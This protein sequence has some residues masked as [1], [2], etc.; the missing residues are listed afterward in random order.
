MQFII[1]DPEYEVMEKAYYTF[2]KLDQNK[3]NRISST[4][5]ENHFGAYSTASAKVM[6]RQIDLDNDGVITKNDWIGYWE[7]VRRAGYKN[8]EI[9]QAVPFL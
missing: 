4:E 7:L 8:A 1:Q 9:M 3:N 6:L 2:K 5:I